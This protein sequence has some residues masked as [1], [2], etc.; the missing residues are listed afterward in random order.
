[1]EEIKNVNL[2]TLGM[3]KSQKH[4]LDFSEKQGS[5]ARVKRNDF[6]KNRTLLVKCPVTALNSEIKP[7]VTE[8]HEFMYWDNLLLLAPIGNFGQSKFGSKEGS[9]KTLN[10]ITFYQCDTFD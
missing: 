6:S 2:E 9:K 7:L 10:Q 3:N 5:N 8:T 4:F 1:M